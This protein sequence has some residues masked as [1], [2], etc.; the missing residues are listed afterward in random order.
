MLKQILLN[1]SVFDMP[2]QNVKQVYLVNSVIIA[3]ILFVLRPFRLH[4]SSLTDLVS[5][6]VS[7]GIITYFSCI[8]CF[9]AVNRWVS[10]QGLR[11]RYFVYAELVLS[12]AI[13]ICI[14][15]GIFMLRSYLNKIPM[16]FDILVSFFY[17]TLIITPIPVVVMRVV[18]VVRELLLIATAKT[19]DTDVPQDEQS[20]P[21]VTLSNITGHESYT[22][23]IN[24]F[25]YANADGNYVE[26]HH[27][28][29]GKLEMY[30]LRCTLK[31]FAAHF[32]HHPHC[33]LCHRSYFV[34]LANVSQIARNKNTAR[35]HIENTADSIPVSRNQLK[36]VNEM[37][38]TSP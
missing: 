15:C 26:V 3:F 25:A 4:E 12:F 20:A 21:I 38:T 28:Q 36:L 10:R 17:Y 7:S 9:A 22:I 35:L 32:T 11:R 16:R 24:T 19:S 37:L 31:Q 27:W 8:V 30:L 33:V 1:T 29:D 6:A 14:S 23:Q 34:N 18:L 5:V 13:I 2:S